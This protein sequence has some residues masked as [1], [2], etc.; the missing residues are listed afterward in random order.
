MGFA[1]EP[2]LVSQ[3]PRPGFHLALAASAA[4]KGFPLDGGSRRVPLDE[5]AASSSRLR[6]FSEP[7]LLEE[8]SCSGLGARR[9]P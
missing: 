9:L 2:P 6:F 4:L 5:P 1:S 8:R 7:I 3:A